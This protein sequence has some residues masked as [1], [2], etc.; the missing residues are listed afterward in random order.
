MK[1][2]RKNINQCRICEGHLALGPRPVVP[3]SKNSKM[4]IIGQAPGTKVHASGITW[5]DTRGKQF[6]KWLDVS[7]EEF[8][9]ID[10]FAL[11][12]LEFCYPGKGK[13]RDLPPRKEC[14]PQWHDLLL[15][16]MPNLK[17]ITFIGI[18]IQ[19]YYLKENAKRTH[20]E[21]ADN[22]PEYFVLPHPSYRNRFW[23]PKTISFEKNVLPE[24]KETVK[25]I[26]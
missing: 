9:D 8:Y 12:P 25:S 19:K 23:L 3:E 24:L 20:T 17:L 13:S 6:R 14:A 7:A 11:V 5:D 4:V 18:Y 22:Y 10:S 1:N 26:I 2:L 15:H 16:K 21:I